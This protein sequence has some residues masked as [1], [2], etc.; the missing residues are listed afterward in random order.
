MALTKQNSWLLVVLVAVV[1]GALGTLVGTM[2]SGDTAAGAKRPAAAVTAF[3]PPITLADFTLEDQTG[4]PFSLSGAR[5]TVVLMGFLYTH[6]GDTCPFEALKMRLVL[7]EL[8]ADAARVTLVAVSTD[9]ERDTVPQVAAY[10]R[11]LGLYDKWHMVTGPLAT[12]QQVYR[13]LGITV[14]KESAEEEQ[15]AVREASGTETTSPA[16]HGVEDPLAGLTAAQVATGDAVARKFSGGYDI[17]HSAPFWVV[18]AEGR[19]R[20]SLDV[21][22]SPAELAKAIR[23]YLKKS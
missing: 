10:S 12:L 15:G 13:D 11:D 4:R 20:L 22:S 14:I 21:S 7:D 2:V 8:G 9:P 3:D 5:G 16:D 19:L 6:C 18:D 17:A 23:G 1:L